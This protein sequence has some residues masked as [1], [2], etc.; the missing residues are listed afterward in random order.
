MDSD[1]RKQWS[2]LEAGVTV[3]GH[4]LT[5]RVRQY[6][7]YRGMSVANQQCHLYGDKKK[8]AAP[9]FGRPLE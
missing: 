4:A 6:G 8:K 3:R 7:V 9:Y 2:G 1:H 5:L